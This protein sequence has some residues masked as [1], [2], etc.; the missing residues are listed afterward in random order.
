MRE[1]CLGL[2]GRFEEGLIRRKVQ[3]LHLTMLDPLLKALVGHHDFLVRPAIQAL[4]TLVLHILRS[5][6]VSFLCQNFE[7][8]A[9]I[10]ES[11]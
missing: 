4:T 6:V 7:T 2:F 5:R 11:T 3:K 10:M 8:Y 1:E 9:S